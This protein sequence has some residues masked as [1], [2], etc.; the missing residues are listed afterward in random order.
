MSRKGIAKTVGVYLDAA[1]TTAASPNGTARL[2][3]GF[4]VISRALE[5]D[6]TPSQLRAMHPS[7]RPYSDAHIEG[8][9]LIGEGLVAGRIDVPSAPLGSSRT[10]RRAAKQHG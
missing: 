1:R 10:S 7:L 2:L 6:V 9:A 4:G 8:F 3:A 5:A